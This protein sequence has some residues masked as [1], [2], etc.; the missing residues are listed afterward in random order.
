MNDDDIFIFDQVICPKYN[1]KFVKYNINIF[2]VY[3]LFSNVFTVITI[4]HSSDT[5]E[6]LNFKPFY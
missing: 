5:F 3:N 6:N 1:F 4:Y 2:V